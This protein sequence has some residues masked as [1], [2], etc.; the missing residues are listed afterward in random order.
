MKNIKFT[1]LQ[2]QEAAHKMCTVR[3]EPDL[4]ESYELTSEEASDLAAMFLKHQAGK[5]A[6]FQIDPRYLDVLQGEFENCIEIATDNLGQGDP[7][8]LSYI[9]SMK[10]A[11]TKIKEAA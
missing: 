6:V 2:I 5:T 9:R 1:Q 3:D 10:N 4:L 11:I 8:Q 7:S